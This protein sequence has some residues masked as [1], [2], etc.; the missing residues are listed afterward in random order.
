MDM[1]YLFISKVFKVKIFG[2][3][4]DS[5]NLCN[6]NYEEVIDYFSKAKVM[7]GYFQYPILINEKNIELLKIR[8]EVNSIKKCD[9]AIHLRG[10]DL[11]HINKKLLE[12]YSKCI[13]ELGSD[14]QF[15]LITNDKEF[16]DALVLKNEQINLTNFEGKDPISDFMF[17]VNT[18]NLICSYS[19]F[20]L[21]AGLLG[22]QDKVYIPLF[23]NDN[24]F[25]KKSMPNLP[26]RFILTP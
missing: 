16:R 12:Y 6:F 5:N 25:S 21:W 11:L 22:N 14:K 8:L 4:H 2:H 24:F 20:S 19:T 1:M 9:N 7:S 10:G 18:N 17:M 26:K 3:I 13:V 23:E 15:T